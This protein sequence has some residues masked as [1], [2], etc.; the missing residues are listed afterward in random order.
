MGF[1]KWLQ[2][3]RLNGAL[4][5]MGRSKL[6]RDSVRESDFRPPKV[7]NDDVVEYDGGFLDHYFTSFDDRLDRGKIIFDRQKAIGA[8]DHFVSGHNTLL[9]YSD[10]EDFDTGMRYWGMTNY[11]YEDISFS[12]SDLS[13]GA[14]MY[15]VTGHDGTRVEGKEYYDAFEFGHMKDLVV[16]PEYLESEGSAKGLIVSRSISQEKEDDYHQ[17]WLFMGDKYGSREMPEMR[18]RQ[19]GISFMEY[20]LSGSVEA[21]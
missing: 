2:E 10:R 12:V 13:I 20:V 9:V 16:A 4:H 15:H 17:Y 7:V 6:V 18:G 19:S 8:I 3:I 11:A 1:T 21:R 5:D 14:R